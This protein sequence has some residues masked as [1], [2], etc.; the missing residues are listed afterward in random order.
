MENFK[1][2]DKIGEGAYSTVYTVKR[3]EDGNLYALKKV[4]I[5]S[6]SEK[7]K[8]NALNEV[9]IL[10]SVNSPFVISYKESF[11]DETDKTLCIIMEYADEGD[12]FQKIT[13]YK[14]LHTSF[15]ENDVWK[16]FIQ[17]TKGLHDLH[18]YNIL[19]RDLKSANVFLFRDGTAKLGDLNVSKISF[20]GLGCTQTGTPY[21]ASPEVW[22]DN[23]YNLKSDIWSLGCLCYELLM[24]KTPFRAESMEALYRK[25]MKGKYPEINKKYSKKFDYVISY[26]LQLKPENRP[27]T[28]QILN[29]P[30]I[31]DKI[32]ELNI[33]PIE[34]DKMNWNTDINNNRINSGKSSSSNINKSFQ[35]NEQNSIS[36]AQIMN[37]NHNKLKKNKSGNSIEQSNFETDN[38]NNKLSNSNIL[39]GSKT[40]NKLNKSEIIAIINNNLNYFNKKKKEKNKFVLNTI[41]I[42]KSLI[43][44][45]NRLPASQYETDIKNKKIFYGLSFQNI[46]KLPSINSRYINSIET[47]NKKENKKGKNRRNIKRNNEMYNSKSVDKIMDENEVQK[48]N[49]EKRNIFNIHN[50][51]NTLKMIVVKDKPFNYKGKIDIIVEE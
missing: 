34:S 21:Y 47:F 42:P 30:E 41:R 9:R 51:F 17:I 19:H 13:L 44:L 8:Q 33:F 3:I 6:L 28:K 16:I 2:I 24:L 49:N 38:N 10:A 12:L 23:P 32:K 7:E 37:V 25:V 5:Q 29:I 11:I 36:Q 4:K 39:N 46:K 14:K 35:S 20:R 31:Q 50:K 26:M 45:N 18:E 22:K 43:N 15:E 40:P 1:I 48:N 27:N